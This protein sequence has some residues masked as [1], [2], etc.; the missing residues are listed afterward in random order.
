VASYPGDLAGLVEVVASSCQE[1][2][3]GREVLEA[4]SCLVAQ[5]EVAKT[6]LA[7][8]EAE[9]ASS[10]PKLLGVVVAAKALELQEDL[11]VEAASSFLEGPEA[12]EASSS[13]VGL[14]EA[15]N[16]LHS[17]P[18]EE[19]AEV[20]IPSVQGELVALEEGASSSLQE[21]LVGVVSY[22]VHHL[23]VVEAATYFHLLVALVGAVARSLEVRE[24]LV[25]VARCW[26]LHLGEEV[27][28]AID[29]LKEDQGG[30]ASLTF[31]EDQGEAEDSFLL[32]DL[33]E[34]VV[35]FLLEDLV[36]VVVSFLLEDLVEMIVS[37]LLEALEVAVKSYH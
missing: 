29:Y 10:Y 27:V 20:V 28:A 13:L 11:G 5:E 31:L 12:V 30:V 33:V 37:F 18:L 3:V 17:Y 35:S 4:S 21:V 26:G 32:G 34:V 19:E 22:L 8:L 15:A 6:Y 16:Y 2:P 36:E 14:E 23:V 1:V 25:E 9:A 7:A 24:V